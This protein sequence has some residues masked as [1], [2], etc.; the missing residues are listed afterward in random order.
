MHAGKGHENNEGFAVHK[1]LILALSVEMHIN[2]NTTKK[3]LNNYGQYFN[4]RRR[5]SDQENIN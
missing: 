4:Y 1:S 3:L 5:E 2:R